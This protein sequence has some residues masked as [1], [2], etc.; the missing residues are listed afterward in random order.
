MRGS[1]LFLGILVAVAIPAAAVHLSAP[2]RHIHGLTASP[3]A[4]PQ[5]LVVHLVSTVPLVLIVAV[6]ANERKVDSVPGGFILAA[7][8]TLVGTLSARLVGGAL[9]ES[10][11]V[12]HVLGR[13]LLSVMLVGP[14]LFIFVRAAVT[15]GTIHRWHYPVSMV[16]AVLP[17][18]V[19]A[20]RLLE[21][22][23]REF[24]TFQGNGRIVKGRGILDAL[25]DLGARPTSPGKDLAV[26]RRE[27]DQE[28]RRTAEL[29][30][31]PLPESVADNDRLR[32]AF[33]LIQLDRMMEAE[34]ELRPLAATDAGAALLLAAVYRDQERWADAADV[35]ARAVAM[36]GPRRDIDLLVTAYE[37]WAEATRSDG[38]PADAESILREALERFPERSAYF[39]LLL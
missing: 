24:E 30:R 20:D 9:S 18:A 32:R 19:Y 4:T 13:S 23:M 17:P 3:F 16:V 6:R 8:M 22:R 27:L 34:D 2:E 11:F 37:G 14:W 5:L 21:T 38:R 12:P 10:G 15:P 26:L 36:L 1:Q 25:S 33:A 7:A 28:I 39:H 29:V 31:R 35:S